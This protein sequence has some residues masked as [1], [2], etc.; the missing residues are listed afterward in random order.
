MMVKNTSRIMVAAEVF[1]TKAG[2]GTLAQ[3]N[4]WTGRTVAAS[5]SFPRTSTIK[6]TMPIIKNDALSPSARAIP[7]MALVNMPGMARGST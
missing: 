6:A 4:I 5:T 1:S 3:R 2:S 7:M